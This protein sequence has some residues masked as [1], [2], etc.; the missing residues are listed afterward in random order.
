MSNGEQIFVSW[1]F[2]RR[3]EGGNDFDNTI[4]PVSSQ[5]FFKKTLEN[6]EQVFWLKTVFNEFVDSKHNEKVSQE[7][8]S[9]EELL[10]LSDIWHLGS[11]KKS[12]MPI[13]KVHAPFASSV[14]QEFQRRKMLIA[15][16]NSQTTSENLQTMQQFEED[17]AK[18]CGLDELE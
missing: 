7:V 1:L 5:Y 18:A 9:F 15:D 2:S 10:N 13:Q 17:W 8:G 16:E 6:S 11:P 3:Y 4:H 14:W 12:P